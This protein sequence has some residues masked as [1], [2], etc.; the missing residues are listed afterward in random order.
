MGGSASTTM[1]VNVV[2]ETINKSIMSF[3]PS[4]VSNVSALNYLEVG[5]GGVAQGNE[6]LIDIT[7]N[8]TSI[9]EATQSSDFSTEVNSQASSELE[10][11]TVSF[12]GD[13]LGCLMNKDTNLQTAISNHVENMNIAEITPAC[14]SNISMVNSMVIKEGA[15]AIDNK[16][17]ILGNFYQK[18]VGSSSSAMNSTSEIVNSTNQKAKITEENPLQVFAEMVSSV[19]SMSSILIICLI[20]GFFFVLAGGFGGDGGPIGAL[21]SSAGDIMEA[22]TPMLGAKGKA[23]SLVLS[24]FN[25]S[26]A[27]TAAKAASAAS[28][29]PVVNKVVVTTPAAATAPK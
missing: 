3:K 15:K 1:S 28:A 16:Q 6:Q 20:G 12:L 22:V 26:K 25:K 21:K 7:S 8:L 4:T 10:K 5:A 14:I 29:A 11:K 23:A 9:Y 24:A 27:A 17:T 19:T 18:C 2:N 13:M